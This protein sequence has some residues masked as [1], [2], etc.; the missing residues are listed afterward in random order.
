MCPKN[1]SRVSFELSIPVEQIF[2]E[3]IGALTY[4][5]DLFVLS[6]STTDSFIV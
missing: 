4:V 6:L 2:R 5:S 1:I 3:S